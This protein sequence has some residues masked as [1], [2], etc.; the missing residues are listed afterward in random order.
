MGHLPLVSV[1]V[2]LDNPPPVHFE[3]VS[4]IG[5]GLL[6]G[7]LGMALRRRQLAREVWGLVRRE[8]GLTECLEAGAA[9]FTT[10]KVEHA[11]RDA[12][13]VV[14]CT[15]V[16]QMRALLESCLPYLAPGTLVTDVGSVKGTLVAGLEAPVRKAGGVFVGSHPIAGSERTGVAHGREDLFEDAV[17]VVTPTPDTPADAVHRVE[18][19]W[20]SV[21]ARPLRLDPGVHDELL[22][23]ASHLPHLVAAALVQAVLRPGLPPEQALLC[24]TGFRDTTRVA[25]GSVEMWR[26]IVVQNRDCLAR[27][28]A[29]FVESLNAVRRAIEA[30]DVAAIE[31]F[32]EI[33]KNQRDAWQGRT[34]GKDLPP[35]DG[36]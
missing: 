6:G 25:S 18:E 5:V 24:A 33:A 27:V 2:R 14:L 35:A 15:P 1:G 28:L 16:G 3:K 30:G 13:L 7:S 12:D 36:D 4:L 11:V 29:E 26:D 8:A 17:C 19:L 21:G 20:R 32:L 22:S 34:P 31:Q 23:R 9:D 10:L